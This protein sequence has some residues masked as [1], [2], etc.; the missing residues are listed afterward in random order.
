M[1]SLMREL[2]HESQMKKPMPTPPISISP[3][4]IASQESPTPIRSPVKMNGAAAGS[5]MAVKYSARFN[6]NTLATFW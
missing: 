3:A 2:F 5:M 4:T 6:L 1:M